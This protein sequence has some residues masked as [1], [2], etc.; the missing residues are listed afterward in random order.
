[1]IITKFQLKAQGVS[2]WLYVTNYLHFGENPIRFGSVVTKKCG[3]LLGM[4]Y[5]P[6]I[7]VLY[8]HL[9]RPFKRS[10]EFS[11]HCVVWVSFLSKFG[12]KGL[13]T[14]LIKN[15]YF[16]MTT[17]PNRMG[18]FAEVQMISYNSI[19][20]KHIQINSQFRKILMLKVWLTFFLGETICISVKDWEKLTIQKAKMERIMVSV[21]SISL[22]VT[23]THRVKD[24]QSSLA[25][26]R[27]RD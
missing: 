7:Q 11:V 12:W 4:S 9:H 21:V 8:I 20:L 24:L 19:I 1:M 23:G 10:V 6:S 2:F 18:F 17:E 25:S 26:L 22:W 5:V 15:P 13:M 27:H 3:F 14:C 16:F